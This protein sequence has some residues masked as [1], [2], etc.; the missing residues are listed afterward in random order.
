MH[1]TC[2]ELKIK[3]DRP[4]C[5]L[6][7]LAIRHKTCLGNLLATKLSL[8]FT[9]VHLLAGLFH[10]VPLFAL[11]NASRGFLSLEVVIRQ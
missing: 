10:A 9:F 3:I 2:G 5:F 1:K 8:I 7:S 11:R 4:W 6:L